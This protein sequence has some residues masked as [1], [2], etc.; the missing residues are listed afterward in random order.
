LFLQRT[1]R[2]LLEFLAV[3]DVVSNLLQVLEGDVRTA[4]G[5]RAVTAV[6]GLYLTNWI[7]P[8]KLSS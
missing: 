7:P 2:P 3:A 4:M 6:T 5:F 8:S 1:E